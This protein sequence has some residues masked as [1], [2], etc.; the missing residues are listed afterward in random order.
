LFKLSKFR[1]KIIKKDISWNKNFNKSNWFYFRICLL[2]IFLIFH[3]FVNF[4]GDIPSPTLPINFI[5]TRVAWNLDTIP[6]I[7]YTDK[8]TWILFQVYF[9]LAREPWYYSRYTSYWQGNMETIPGILYAGKGS[10]NLDTIPGILYSGKG[11]WILFQVYFI[12]EREPGHYSRY[13]LYWQGL[14]GT[15]RY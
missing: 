6:G 7:L 13:T 11:T 3:H 10:W 9:I 1:K 15:Y 5:L 8:G 4:Q 14:P 12:L 2:N